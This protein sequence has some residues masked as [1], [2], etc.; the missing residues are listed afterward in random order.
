MVIYGNVSCYV[1]LFEKDYIREE[2]KKLHYS[3]SFSTV[4]HME[5][6]IYRSVIDG[7]MGHRP[8]EGTWRLP[9]WLPRKGPWE[10]CLSE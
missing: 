8:L 5:T 1:G 6:A 9:G 4:K 7:G 2:R 10:V 3:F